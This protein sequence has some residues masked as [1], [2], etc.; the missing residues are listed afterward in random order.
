[1][2]WGAAPTFAQK[3]LPKFDGKDFYPP[4][5]IKQNAQLAMYSSPPNNPSC[6]DSQTN[7]LPDFGQLFNEPGAPGY[8][9]PSPMRASSSH[10][11]LVSLPMQSATS[12][13]RFNVQDS[14][15]APQWHTQYG[16]QDVQ[17]PRPVT[18][19][20]RTEIPGEDDFS[21]LFLER[22]V[23]GYKSPDQGNSYHGQAQSSVV[24]RTLGETPQRQ[25]TDDV[26]QGEDSDNEDAGSVDSWGAPKD[27]TKW[28]LIKNNAAVAE[29]EVTENDGSEA[30][31]V[32]INLKA[33]HYEGSPKTNVDTSWQERVAN[34]SKYAP[35]TPCT[36]VRNK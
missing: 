28:D 27:H 1:L 35:Q 7:A 32:E 2:Y 3:G 18:P 30:S 14:D 13:A 25:N 16:N 36:T 6:H 24:S 23:P 15:R 34:F 19:Q 33:Q 5:P 9:T 12:S 17:V 31:S 8:K 26:A 11:N 20:G 21:N 22:G 29:E 10:S 4:S